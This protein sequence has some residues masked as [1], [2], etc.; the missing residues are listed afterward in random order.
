[1]TDIVQI[2]QRIKKAKLNIVTRDDTLDEQKTNK[3][4]F[5]ELDKAIA[6]LSELVDDGK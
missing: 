1:M 3:E 6:E 4:A 2:I 5:A